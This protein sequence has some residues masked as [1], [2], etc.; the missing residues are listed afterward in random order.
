MTYKTSVDAEMDNYSLICDVP[1]TYLYE[2]CAEEYE[3][4]ADILVNHPNPPKG[5]RIA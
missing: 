3:D 2:G 5:V 4:L 1:P